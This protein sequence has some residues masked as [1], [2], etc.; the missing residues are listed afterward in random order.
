MN[1]KD[2]KEEYMGGFRGRRGKREMN[3]YLKKC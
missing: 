2:S 3:N 1:L